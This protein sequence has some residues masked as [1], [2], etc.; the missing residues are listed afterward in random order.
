MGIAPSTEI[1][2]QLLLLKKIRLLEEEVE[3]IQ[4]EIEERRNITLLE[5]DVSKK[6]KSEKYE[7]PTKSISDY[8]REKNK[9]IKHLKQEIEKK[10]VEILQLKKLLQQKD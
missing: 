2:E 6:Q 8:L 7:D 1:S 10:D 4:K 5:E 9:K 3:R